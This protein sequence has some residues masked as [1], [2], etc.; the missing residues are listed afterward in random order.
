MAD[1][2][3]LL[4]AVDAERLARLALELVSIP[5]PTGQTRQ[6]ALRYAQRLK[7]VGAEVSLI[8]DWPQAPAVVA[9]LTGSSRGPTLTL[10][11]HLDHVSLP[12]DPPRLADGV[13]NGRG[14]ADMKGALACAA[15]ALRVVGNAGVALRGSLQ[16]I[17]H[18]HHE[19]PA[20]CSEDLAELCRR[21]LGGDAA[22]VCECGSDTLPIAQRGMARF[23]IGVARSGPV[24]HELRVPPGTPNPAIA[25]GRVLSAL[26]QEQ[27]RLAGL[28]APFVGAESLFIG[29]V[30]AGDS[31][32]TLPAE[33]WVEGTR[34]WLYTRESAAVRTELMNLL[35]AQ[36]DGSGLT[37]TLEWQTVREGFFTPP[38]AALV[39][40][41]RSACRTVSGVE[42]PLTASRVV[43]DA[44]V[45][46]Q[47]AGIP[48]VYHGPAGRGMHGPRESVSVAEL[49]RATQVFILAACHYLGAA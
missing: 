34:R 43:A 33:C 11:G 13:L 14:A 3:A 46:A 30:H 28:T 40:A 27:E 25:M 48:A 19:L 47:V 4:A 22:I 15:E 1:T 37:W 35:A 16:I 32:S 31:F 24:T 21:G 10:S 26:G 8:T 38:E 2:Q 9:R 49:V 39:Q 29:Q 41:V 12:H 42:P 20:G 17:A 45:F 23:R 5:S 18:G 36:L 44:A 7:E 6:V